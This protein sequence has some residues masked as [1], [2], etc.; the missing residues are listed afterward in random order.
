MVS[1]R[2]GGYQMKERVGSA[3]GEGKTGVAF[4]ERSGT[5]EEGKGEAK[6]VKILDHP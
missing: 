5:D 1:R 4:E 6:Q 3:E 2:L